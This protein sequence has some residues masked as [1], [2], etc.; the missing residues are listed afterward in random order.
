MLKLH[1]YSN[2]NQ[3]AAIL[4]QL[5]FLL[6]NFFILLLGTTLLITIALLFANFSI[7]AINILLSFVLSIILTFISNKYLFKE[8]YIKTFLLL[9]SII[10][11]IFVI[12]IILSSIIYDTYYDGQW[13]HQNAI[14]ELIDG[15]NPIY[16]TR[17]NQISLN[18]LSELSF[19]QICRFPKGPWICAA[20]LYKITNNLESCKAINFLL[21]ISSFFLS[22]SAC[23]IFIKHISFFKSII[24]SLLVALNPV[25]IYQSLSFYV[26]GQLASLISCIFALMLLLYFHP[27]WLT[28]LSLL[29]CL[30]LLINLKFTG[31]IYTLIFGILFSAFFYSVNKNFAKNIIKLYLAG[32]LF[33]V[34]LVGYNPY[35]INSL[36]YA[37]PFYPIFSHDIIHGNRPANFDNLNRF[38]SFF[39]SIL[40][41][42]ANPLKSNRAYLKIPFSISLNEIKAFGAADVRTGGFGPF[43][44]GVFLLAYISLILSMAYK[45]IPAKEAIV[46]AVILSI[47]VFAISE[48]WWARFVPQLWLIPII[49]IILLL[50]NEKFL[51]SKI[52]GWSLVIILSINI[53]LIGTFYVV[54]NA[55]RTIKINNMLVSLAHQPG[56]VHVYF[57]WPSAKIK[58]QKM[59]IRY[60]EVANPENL[61]SNSISLPYSYDNVLIGD[62]K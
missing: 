54:V 52:I 7:S 9:I 20:A 59:G 32:I 1:L 38:E 21:I 57:G 15:W 6:G 4:M 39:Y 14:I 45:L 8:H 12:F 62:L 58:F 23:C 5:S 10:I 61:S 36:A 28:R 44:G 30:I 55:Y 40:S 19:T 50:Y 49:S 26:D 56:P 51:V 31:L 29:M 53:L 60:E 3:K 17:T 37:N 42:S 13:Y 2:P 34:L 24:I 33:G 35:I 48:P 18:N 27:Y 22:F 11:I 25:A 43:F 16:Q 46:V 47:S 41:T